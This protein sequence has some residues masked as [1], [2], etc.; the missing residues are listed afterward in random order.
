MHYTTFPWRV[1]IFYTIEKIKEVNKRGKK[2]R[3]TV[4]EPGAANPRLFFYTTWIRIHIKVLIWIR[5]HDDS[6]NP[7]PYIKQYPLG[8]P[9]FFYGSAIKAFTPPPSLMAIKKDLFLRLPL[10][11]W[12]FDALHLTLNSEN[13][14]AT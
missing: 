1:K 10:W 4:S 11:S 9:P 13:Y 5:I 14:I 2:H 8:K 3:Q 12:I 6:R 7:Q